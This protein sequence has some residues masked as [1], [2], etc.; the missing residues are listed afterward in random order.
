MPLLFFTVQPS[1]RTGW[2]H[3][4]HPAGYSNPT[5]ELLTMAIQAGIKTSGFAAY[6]MALV[7]TNGVAKALLGRGLTVA[8]N[9]M[10]T[11][12]MGAFAGPVG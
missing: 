8:G 11:R 5:P 7:V 9:A 4:L 6:Q 10:L 12:T 2:P 3:I 1:V